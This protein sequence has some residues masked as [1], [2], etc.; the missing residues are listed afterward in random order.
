MQRSFAKSSEFRVGVFCNSTQARIRRGRWRT[1]GMDQLASASALIDKCR[2]ERPVRGLRPHAAG[3]AARWFLDKFPGDVAYVWHAQ[4]KVE[5][6]VDRMLREGIPSALVDELV[7]GSCRDA[8]SRSCLD[9]VK[10][11]FSNGGSCDLSRP[12][13]DAALSALRVDASYPQ[14][15]REAW[16]RL[17]SSC[18]DRQSPL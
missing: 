17:A 14:E 13:I 2:P 11:S 6:D 8:A 15:L 18:P 4:G 3:R 9:L 12:R 7:K 10:A 16:R 1:Y 5:R